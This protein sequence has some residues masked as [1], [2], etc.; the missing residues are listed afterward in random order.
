MITEQKLDIRT[1]TMGISLYSCAHPDNETALSE[2]IRPASP[3]SAK[4]LVKTG[5]ALES[6]FGIP[7]VNK[8]ISVTPVE[9]LWRRHAGD[10]IVRGARAGSPRQRNTGVNYIGGYSALVQKGMTAADRR[11]HRV[12]FRKRSATTERVCSSVNVG[13]TRAGI[14]MDAV[15]LDRADQSRISRQRPRTATLPAA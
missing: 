10:P 14:D 1:I 5:E 11:A 7:I 9:R 13:S 3:R 6:E 12:A 2:R 4:D 8:R 15:A